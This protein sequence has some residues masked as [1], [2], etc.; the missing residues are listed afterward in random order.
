MITAE[1]SR[2]EILSAVQRAFES[3]FEI[4]GEEVGLGSGLFAELDLDSLDAAD[5]RAQLQE[6]MGRVLPEARFQTVRT[7]RDVVVLLEDLAREGG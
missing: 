6:E 4:P 7:V 5:L 3:L 2:D 1:T